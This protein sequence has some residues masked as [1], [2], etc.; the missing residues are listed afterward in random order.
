MFD[1]GSFAKVINDHDV[2]LDQIRVE[3]SSQN[4]LVKWQELVF[5][6]ASMSA[7]LFVDDLNHSLDVNI[8]LLGEW[9]VDETLSVH[10]FHCILL[11]EFELN[12]DDIVLHIVKI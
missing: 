11:Y 6:P 3:N 5:L 2:L 8:I 7:I 9:Q 1:D 4:R 10:N 12:Q